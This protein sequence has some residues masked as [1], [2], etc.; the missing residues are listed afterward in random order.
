MRRFAANV[1]RSLLLGAL[2][3]FLN[4]ALSAEDFFFNSA[5]I[6][7]HYVVEGKGEAVLLLHGFGGDIQ[8][9]SAGGMIKEL[10]KSYKVIAMDIRGHGKSDKPQDPAAY[11]N[12][13]VNDP[14]RLL[15]HLK[16]Q[17]AHIVG[18]SMGGMIALALVGSHPERLLS[19]MIGGAGWYPPEADPIPAVRRQL[20]DSLE[21]GKGI[22]PLI[23]SL[24]PA[25]APQPTPE[26]IAITN[27]MFLSRND[28][29]ALAALQR[30]FA[31]PPDKAR[32]LVNSI[33]VLASIG[34][35]DPRRSGV[36]GLDGWIPNLK[37]VVIPKA[38]HLTAF[39][40]P[41]F[42]NSLKTFLGEHSAAAG[43]KQ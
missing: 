25:G 13:L 31:A 3:L 21:Q 1:K 39:S 4:P 28:A 5:G 41:E 20:A 24:N 36:D 23:V 2:I 14:I 43:G 12:E 42:L 30:N 8:T 22:E 9:W 34:E 19:A 35:M 29:L 16:I 26:Q 38:N 40:N 11:G 33:P 17:K 32:L 15:D 6:N 37:T 7:I 10:A 27:K 18:Y